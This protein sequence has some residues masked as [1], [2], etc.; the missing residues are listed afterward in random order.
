M[1]R[2]IKAVV[3]RATGWLEAAPRWVWTLAF[4]GLWMGLRVFWLD[5]DPGVPSCW[6]YGYNA[7]DEGYYL[8]GGKEKLLWGTFVDLSR[9]EAFTYGFSPLTHYLCY[10]ACRIGGL[11]CWTWR[12]PFCCINFLAWMCM[13]GHVQKR[14]NSLEAFLLCAAISS[15]PLMVAYERTA[16]NDVLI[17]SLLAI[18]FVLGCGRGAIRLCASAAVL[19]LIVLVKP[20]VFALLPCAV[21]AV[22]LGGAASNRRIDWR[23]LSVFAGV[24]AISVLLYK[25]VAALMVLPDAANEGVS[26][27]EVVKRTTTHYPLPSITAFHDHFR[28]LSSFP[29]VPSA[30]MLGFVGGLLVPVPLAF[31]AREACGSRNWGKMLLYLGIPA[32]VG[33]VSVMNT[34]YTHYFIPVIMLLPAL[35]AEAADAADGEVAQEGSS[36]VRRTIVI[37]VAAFAIAQTLLHYS[38]FKLDPRVAQTVFSQVYNFPRQIVWSQFVP[39][40]SAFVLVGTALVAVGSAHRRWLHCLAYSVPI[41]ALASVVI[42]YLP[43]VAMAPYLKASPRGGGGVL[44]ADGFY[45]D[46]LRGDHACDGVVPGVVA[47]ARRS[48]GVHCCG[49]GFGIRNDAELEPRSDR[50]DATRN[51]APR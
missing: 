46:R 3:L 6:E 23:G 8:C 1:D 14:R 34:L 51:E 50:I 2:V 45:A 40:A 32:Y 24:F 47:Q 43:S 20:S 10:L 31:L 27:F 9:M 5:C 28:G 38:V 29:R 17:G 30:Q 7:T 41:A 35:F 42:A 25:L 11:S 48:R 4:A 22:L 39:F 26:I 33:A 16:S 13:F 44:R 12:I 19:G 15:L 18:S 21:S 49:G 37:L 36:F